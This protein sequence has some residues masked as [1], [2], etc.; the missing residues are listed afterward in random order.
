MPAPADFDWGNPGTWIV[1]LAS[2]GL[3]LY[4]LIRT[5]KKDSRSDKQEEQIDTSVQ[6]IITTL[7]AEVE[8]LV[9]RMTDM[10]SELVRLH[11]LNAQCQNER[12]DYLKERAELMK[13]R[14]LMIARLERYE[15]A[16][17]QAKLL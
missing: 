10:E 16:D 13:E 11:E 5:F 8:R 4:T 15:V 2:A 12:I 14:T 9:R 17:V 7:R 3:G 1:G 6:Q